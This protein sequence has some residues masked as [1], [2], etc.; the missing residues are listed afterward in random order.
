VRELEDVA[1]AF[2]RALS[3]AG[4]DYVFVGGIA[5]LAWGQPRATMDVDALVDLERERLEAL[6]EA[7]REEGFDVEA[8]ELDAA[9][10]DGSHVTVFDPGSDYHVDVTPAKSPAERE[11]IQR[12]RTVAFRGVDLRF[13]APEDVVAFKLAFGS[14]QDRQ[15]ARSILARQW[16][17]LDREALAERVRALG[18]AD[19]LETLEAAV[20]EALAE[21]DDPAR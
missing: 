14:P 19:D 10:Q 16:G 5:V 3:E 8:W 6:E 11:E 17:A 4:V 2:H 21:D 1:I 20:E 15:D 18:V 12:A 9:A 7:L 13:A